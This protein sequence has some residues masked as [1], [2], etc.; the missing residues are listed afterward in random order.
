MSVVISSLDIAFDSFTPLC[1]SV[2]FKYELI[3][4]NSSLTSFVSYSNGIVRGHRFSACKFRLL[5]LRDRVKHGLNEV[6]Q[7]STDCL[8]FD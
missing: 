7:Y 3:A 2:L 5:T 6:R 1:E 8:W 4:R